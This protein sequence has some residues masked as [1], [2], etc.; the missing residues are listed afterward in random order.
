MSGIDIYMVRHG[1]TYF[2]L[3]RRFQGFSD[4]PLTE[5]GIQDGHK[6]GQRLAKI[7]FD[8]AYSSDL[9]RAIHTA[10]YALS[11]NQ[12]GSP[13]EPTTLPNFREENFGSFEGRDSQ[14]T[15]TDLN[16]SL[17]A[18]YSTY[19]DM[20]KDLGMPAVMDHFAAHDPYH[21][22]ESYQ[23]FLTRVQNGFNQLRD[24]HQDGDKVLLVSHG[25]TI[26]AIADYLGHPEMAAQ[27][28]HNGGIMHLKL[29]ADGADILAFNDITT[30]FE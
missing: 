10:R 22:A 19:A 27:P 2:N 9:T 4:A 28:V 14:V 21:L 24:L 8:G 1:Q 23:D 20:V 13:V 6:A 12:A 11:E 15:L 18:T 29:T 17:P 25:T 7:H 30:N 26:R 5:S 16:A 3:L